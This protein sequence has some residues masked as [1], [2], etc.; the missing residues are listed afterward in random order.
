MLQSSS[1]ANYITT[2]DG[3]NYRKKSGSKEGYK[4]LVWA[5]LKKGTGSVLKF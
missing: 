4:M 5:H 2:L 1:I 3:D